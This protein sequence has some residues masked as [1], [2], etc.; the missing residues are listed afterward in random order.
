[1]K[2]WG[3]IWNWIAS[4]LGRAKEHSR[5]ILP[6][7]SVQNLIDDPDSPKPATLYLIGENG[8]L[9]HAVLICPCGCGEMIHLNLLEDDEPCWRVELSSSGVSVRPSVWRTTGCRSHFIIR[10]GRVIW[11]ADG[12]R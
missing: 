6:K 8:I 4:F 9:W 11:C 10:N 5:P 12:L 1:M 2:F 7:F 3:M